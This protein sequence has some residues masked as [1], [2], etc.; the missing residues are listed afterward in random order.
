[1]KFKCNLCGVTVTQLRRHFGQWPVTGFSL[2]TQASVSRESL[3]NS[4]LC[5]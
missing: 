4:V 3:A 2:M 5:R 1:M